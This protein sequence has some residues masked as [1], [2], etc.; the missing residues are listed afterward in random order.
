[1]M[2]RPPSSTLFPYTTLFR[3]PRPKVGLA[4]GGDAP[5]PG[6][7]LPPPSLK[8]F[9]PLPCHRTADREGGGS[10]GRGRVQHMEGSL[11]DHHMEVVDQLP[12]AVDGLGPDA[13]LPPHQIVRPDAWDELLQRADEALLGEGAMQLGETGPPVAAREP[14]KPRKGEGLGEIP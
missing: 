13:A 4:P 8:L 3:S 12:G 10:G 7:W 9:E 2:R 6:A 11:P 5:P 14:P 1:M